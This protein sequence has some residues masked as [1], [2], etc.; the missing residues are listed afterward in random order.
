LR[1]KE[2][3][4]DLAD[5]VEN[6]PPVA[7]EAR[8]DQ[9]EAAA[10]DFDFARADY[11]ILIALREDYLAHLESVKGVM[12]SITQNRMRLARMTGA[13]A[14]S[15]VVKPGGRLVSQDV[16]ESIVR[17]VAGG[18]ELANAEVEPS[19][20]SLVC[21]ELNNVRVT[22][23]RAEISADL[24]AGSRDTILTEFYERALA[25]QPAGVRRVIEDE[26][27]TE[28]GYRESL[29]EERVIKALATAGAAPDALAKLVDRRVLRIEERLDM[30]RVELTHDVLCSVVASSRDLRHERE[31]R[32]EAERQLEAQREREAATKRALV[33]ART[34]AAVCAVLAVLAAASAVF[35]WVNLRRAR[36]ADVQAQEARV[37]AE[38]ARGD[39]EKLVG[40]LIEDFYEE[41][42]PTG[43][44]ETMGKLSHQAVKYFEGLPPQLVT[45]QTR[46]YQ[47]MALIREGGALLAGDK[48]EPGNQ[49]IAQARAS[50]EK[51]RAEGNTSEPVTYGLALALFTPYLAWG[52]IGGPESKPTDL[53]QALELLKPI[54]Y[55]PD[56]SRQ[57]KLLY[58]DIL[59]HYSHQQ[60]KEQGIA[61]CEESRKVLAAMGAK[62]LSDLT[63]ASIYA[64]T[65]DSQARHSMVLGRNE[66]AERLEREVYDIAEGVLAKRPGDIRSMKN[67]ALAANLLGD[68]SMTRHDYATAMRYAERSEQAG[69]DL[70]RFNPSDLTSWEH[71]VRGRDQI[72][73]ILFEQGLVN[74]SLDKRRATVAL[75]K[76]ERL[77]DGP[78]GVFE[79]TYYNLATFEAES[80]QRAAAER[81]MAAA[82]GAT[83]RYI[84]QLAADHPTRALGLSRIKISKA[85]LQ[86]LLG[87]FSAAADQAGSTVSDLEKLK[88]PNSSGGAGQFH[89]N[90]LQGALGVVSASTLRLGRYDEAEAAARR[91]LTLP[92]N[93]FTDPLYQRA[94]QQ[95]SFAHA[96]AK[97]G[98]GAEAL[99]VLK[100]A[101]AHY[102]R[103]K[104]A[105]ATGTD[106]R[107]QYAMA[108][109]VSAIAQGDDAAGRQARQ[110]ALAEAAEQL[111]LMSPEA[112][113]LSTSRELEQ[114]ISA[115][116]TVAP[117]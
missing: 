34:I 99:D 20:L 98:H 59:N 24:L 89:N 44:L 91:R 110:L 1:A 5:L 6:R 85:R 12:P 53:P 68:I 69:E 65:A 83:E 38:K 35:G 101:L 93:S 82:T 27:L 49:S 61:S 46:I 71:W 57:A 62:D 32:D 100:P 50:F 102:Q 25:D 107:Y 67:R 45:P 8:L 97:R 113:Q 47:G 17:F 90:L 94:R 26:L 77:T 115:A 52:P 28:S 55:A 14:L 79:D 95:V 11:R 56:G 39:A 117:S 7:L 74:R 92:T 22:K 63:A 4:A 30:R 29:A 103:E 31:A 87:N 64:D 109:Y 111:S 86:L 33:R 51:L 106:F 19:L 78:G 81:S 76:D 18:A 80:G 16:A 37:L 73:D 84:N 72:A 13:Q 54:V 36:V 114:W 58:A 108:L 66:D 96:L 9:D 104:N 3:L 43:R 15:A 88:F 10:E 70:V 48:I 75:A 60:A 116:R 2:F 42:Q 105:G 21:R 40:F 23:G 41:L 112:R